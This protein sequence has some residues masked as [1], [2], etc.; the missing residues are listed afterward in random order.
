L[1]VEEKR[2]VEKIIKKIFAGFSK[3]EVKRHN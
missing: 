2:P 3:T 1:F